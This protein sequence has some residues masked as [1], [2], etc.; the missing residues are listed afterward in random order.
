MS[1]LAVKE[2]EARII[3][4]NVNM[5]HPFGIVIKASDGLTVLLSV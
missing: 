1:I 4:S 3:K 2:L 5:E